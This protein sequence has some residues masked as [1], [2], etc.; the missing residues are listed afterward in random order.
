MSSDKKEDRLGQLG[1]FKGA[2]SSAIS[3]LASAADEVT[4]DAGHVLIR[5]GSNHQELYILETG[6]ATVHVDGEQVAEIP[7][8][9]LIGELGYFVKTPASATVTA[10]AESTVLVI[11]YNRFAQILSDNPPLVLTIATELAERLHAMDVRLQHHH[12]G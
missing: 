11:P 1:L 6:G 3:H 8:G 5:E 2:D 7:A 4:V 9:E 10:S 12:M